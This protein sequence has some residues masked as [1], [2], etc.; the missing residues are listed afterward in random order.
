MSNDTGVMFTR[1]MAV[2][3]IQRSQQMA[4]NSGVGI[5]NI[6]G[7]MVSGGQPTVDASGNV[8]CAARTYFAAYRPKYLDG[9]AVANNANLL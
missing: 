3:C 9:Y 2:P 7:K 4:Q 6:D 8:V 1:A 5:V